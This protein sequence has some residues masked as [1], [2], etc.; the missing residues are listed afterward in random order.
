MKEIS[1]TA[2]AK[3]LGVKSRSHQAVCINKIMAAYDYAPARRVPVYEGFKYTYLENQVKDAAKKE[4][5]K[6]AAAELEARTEKFFGPTPA[7][8]PAQAA[9]QLQDDDIIAIKKAIEGNSSYVCQLGDR[10]VRVERAVSHF[11]S[12]QRILVIAVNRLLKAAGL[13]QVPE[14]APETRQ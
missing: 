14:S 7:K 6:A 4:A 1:Q 5:A 8:S 3:A 2:A 12:T 10:L 9:L 11:E 13:Q